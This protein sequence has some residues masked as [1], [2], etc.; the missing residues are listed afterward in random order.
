MGALA[1]SLGLGLRQ[2]FDGAVLRIVLKSVAVS[3]VLFVL[4]ASGGWFLLDWLLARGGLDDSLVTGGE[5]IRGVL[6]LLIALLGLWL[7]W[8][9]V[10]MAVI[11]FF[12]DEVVHAVEARFYPQAASSAR[13]LPLPE[14]ARNAAASAGRALLVNLLAL[15]FALVLLFT[16]V[17]TFTLFLLV[18]AVLL[19]R[20]L[21][22]MV[23]LR[24]RHARGERA[25]IGRVER[26]LLGGVVAAM[27]AVPFV[28]F[29][30]PVLGAASATH[31]L[32]RNSRLQKAA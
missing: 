20:E 9:I 29:L 13:D 22:D 31:L 4:V 5:A 25:P 15:P 10:A 16:G 27:L 12:A 14:Q 8:R 21:Q 26:F 19:G 28:N 3:L 7:V 17:G 30:A 24:H 2:L 32:H 6:S 1:T 18:N 23:W 11:Q